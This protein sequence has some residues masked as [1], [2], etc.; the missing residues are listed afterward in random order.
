M[1]AAG[2]TFGRNR[3]GVWFGGATEDQNGNMD[4]TWERA[5]KYN[6]GLDLG[7][8]QDA[9]TFTGDVFYERR[10]NIWPI[11]APYRLHWG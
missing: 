10:T 4:V 6:V 2:Y 9:I 8:W 1:G 7:L 5:Q 3:D 11:P